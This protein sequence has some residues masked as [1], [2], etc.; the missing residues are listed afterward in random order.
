MEGGFGRQAGEKRVPGT[1][2]EVR[3]NGELVGVVR[4]TGCEVDRRLVPPGAPNGWPVPDD[5]VGELE[6][7]DSEGSVT[8]ANGEDGGAGRGRRVGAYQ[9]TIYC[10][11]YG[12]TTLHLDNVREADR[13]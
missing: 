12:T 8:A 2:M 7:G 13:S 5:Q 11:Q 10:G 6:T 4:G 9:S 1:G 3:G